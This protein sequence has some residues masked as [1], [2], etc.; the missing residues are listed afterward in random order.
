[1]PEV[2]RAADV[3]T[4]ASPWYRSFEIV[5]VEAMASGLPVVANNDPIR[6]EIVGDAGILVDPADMEGYA[7]ALEKAL[8]TNWENKPINQAKKFDWDIIAGKYE[9]LIESLLR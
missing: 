3:F 7:E 9:R 5:L 6:K 4:L 1:M 8:N 2:Y